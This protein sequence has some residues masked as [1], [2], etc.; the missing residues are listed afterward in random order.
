MK[1]KMRW[2]PNG[3]KITPIRDD[4][5]DK[6]FP[7]WLL[8]KCCAAFKVRPNDIGFSDDVNRATADVQSEVQARVGRKPLLTYL[9]GIYDSWLQD[10]LQL[11]VE[12]LWDSGEERDDKLQEAQAS[13]IYVEMGAQSVDEVRERVLGLPVDHQNPIPRYVMTRTGLVPLASVMAISGDEI[14]PDS[15]APTADSIQHVDDEPQPAAL[16]GEEQKINDIV[17]TVRRQPQRPAALARALTSVP[18]APATGFEPRDAAPPA[19]VTKELATFARFAKSRAGRPWRDFR[20]RHVQ[21]DQADLLNRTAL[22]DPEIAVA[23]AR[24]LAAV[25][26]EE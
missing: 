14:D 26:N 18:G 10:D 8:K 22:L 2:V 19:V 6:D 21:P 13:Q 5:F 23:T 20:F 1:R 12:W 4:S 9:K 24:V 17:G 15:L 16:A 25:H 3:S 11:P 7:E